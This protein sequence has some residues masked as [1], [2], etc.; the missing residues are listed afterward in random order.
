MQRESV[1]KT[2]N[3]YSVVAR[4]SAQDDERRVVVER[5][6]ALGCPQPELG[7]AIFM[8]LKS[9]EPGGGFDDVTVDSIL[10]ALA[11][12]YTFEIFHLY[13]FINTTA[14]PMSYQV[15]KRMGLL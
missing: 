3:L 15:I 11:R 1:G 6:S 13:K 14:Q 12:L 8:R 5:L 9:L 2:E 7:G 10:G 4:M